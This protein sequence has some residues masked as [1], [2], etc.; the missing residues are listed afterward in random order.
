MTKRRLLEAATVRAPLGSA[1]FLKSRLARY[2]E[3]FRF[4]TTPSR[5]ICREQAGTQESRPRLG[6]PP[7]PRA[8]GGGLLAVCSRGRLARSAVGGYF[9][10][11]PSAV[12]AS[13]TLGRA[14]IRST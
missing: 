2:F 6:L 1:V 3:S 8:A 14:R 10:I 4:A 5:G 9:L 12:M 7:Q 13:M 11:N